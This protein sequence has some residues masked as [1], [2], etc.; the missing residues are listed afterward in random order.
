MQRVGSYDKALKELFQQDRSSLLLDLLTGGVPVGQILNVELARIVERWADL[1]FL[2]EDESIFHLEFQTR[3]DKEMPYR[4][5]I[6]CV[7]LG[8]KYRRRVRQ[9]VIYL[10][11]AKMRMENEVDLGQTKLAYTLIDIREIGADTLMASGR[12]ADLALAMLAHGGA[13]RILAIL[14]KA[15]SL[16]GSERDTVLSQLVRLSGLRQLQDHLIMELNQMLNPTDPFLKITLVQDMIR[17][18]SLNA[19]IQMLRDQFR[20][21]F[22][23]LPKWADEKLESATSVQVRRWSKKIVTADTL[24]GVLGKK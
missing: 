5:G 12:P 17:D 1:V 24:E 18:A 20:T 16:K 10:G 13:E 9:A 19:R 14:K 11:E 2:L 7:L 22:R 3:N 6:Y 15:A 23:T 4:Q 8:Q 21:K